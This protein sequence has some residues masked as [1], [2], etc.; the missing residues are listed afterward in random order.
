[1]LA[2]KICSNWTQNLTGTHSSAPCESSGDAILCPS[3]PPLPPSADGEEAGFAAAVSPSL[4]DPN[5]VHICPGRIA[6][7]QAG[8]SARSALSAA[9]AGSA[10]LY[11]SSGPTVFCLP[12]SVP[13]LIQ[14][15]I[16]YLLLFTTYRI[17]NLFP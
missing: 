14:T 3:L 2:P 5:A 12:C 4:H 10:L 17:C 7:A 1:M 11:L 8:P 15:N 13:F 16:L 6:T 9:A